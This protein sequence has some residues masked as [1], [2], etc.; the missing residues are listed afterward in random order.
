MEINMKNFDLS[1]FANLLN[2]FRNE[3]TVSLSE[4]DGDNG[5]AIITKIGKVMRSKDENKKFEMIM[6]LNSI[7][8]PSLRRM[9]L[10][11]HNILTRDPKLYLLLIR[12][13][14]HDDKRE[15]YTIMEG[16]KLVLRKI[17]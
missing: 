4:V 3:I 15:G 14:L 11:R 1:G 10:L 9:N 8:E 17:I 5:A 12:N 16:N 6:M 13:G 2:H 7:F